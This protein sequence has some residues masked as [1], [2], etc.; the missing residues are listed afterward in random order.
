MMKH[1][2]ALHDVNW[3]RPC[4]GPWCSKIVLAP[5]PHQEHIESISDFIWRFCVNYRPLNAVTKPFE[6]PIPR[7]DA[8]LDNFGDSKGRLHFIS[9]DG[10]T[11]YHQIA[12]AENDQEKLAFMGPDLEKYCY[13]VMPFGPRNAPA[14]YTAMMRIMNTEVVT[15]FN[16]RYPGSINRVGTKNIIDD[17]LFWSTEPMTCLCYFRCVCEIFTKYRLS[18]NPKKCDFFRQRIEWLGHDLRPDGNSPAQSKFN[19]IADWVQPTTGSS[20]ASFIGLITFYNR[21][22]PQY[23]QK[24]GPLRTLAKQFHRRPIP[25]E[26]WTAPLPDLFRELKLAITSDPCLARFDESM[27]I[28]LKTDWSKTGMSYILMQPADD[29]A[30]RAALLLLSDGGTNTFD[31]LMSGARLRPIRFGSRRCTTRERHFHSFVGEAITGRWAIGQNRTYLWGAHFFWM[32]DCNS[33]KELL[34]YSGEIHQICR[35]SQELLGYHFTNLHRPARMMRDVDAL[36]RFYDDPLIREYDATTTALCSKDRQDRPAVYDPN[37]FPEQAFKCPNSLPKDEHLPSVS[38]SLITTTR[39]FSPRIT[40]PGF[41]ATFPIQLVSRSCSP[42]PA[43]SPNSSTAFASSTLSPGWISIGSSTGSIAYALSQLNPETA[44]TPV[45]IIAHDTLTAQL[46]YNL[47]TQALT[48]Q[49]SL[50]NFHA[51][52]HPPTGPHPPPNG[53]S[54]PA[55]NFI[56]R[57]GLRGLDIHSSAV[58]RPKQLA[59]LDTVTS[60]LSGLRASQ[61]TL[62]CFLLSSPILP[63]DHDESRYLSQHLITSPEISTNWNVRCGLTSSAFFGDAIAASRWIAIGVRRRANSVY[64][65]FPTPV[66]DHT[67]LH[68]CFEPHRNIPS[69]SICPFTAPVSNLEPTFLPPDITTPEFIPRTLPFTIA[70]SVDMPPLPVYDPDYPGPEPDCCVPS[71]QPHDEPKLSF[72]IPFSDRS[73]QC[74]ARYAHP[75]EIFRAYS[76]PVDTC[77]NIG[78]YLDKNPDAPSCLGTSIPFRTALAFTRCLFDCWSNPCT[79]L[80]SESVTHCLAY[81]PKPLPTQPDWTAAYLDDPD[82]H[83]ICSR[84]RDDPSCQWDKPTLN[85]VDAQYRASLRSTSIAFVNDRLVLYQRLETN[86]RQLML[87]IVPRALRRTIFS[88]YHASPTTGHMRKFKTLHRLRLRFFWPHMRANVESW[89]KECAHCIATSSHVRR[90]SELLFSWPVSVPFFILHVDLW[91]PGHT[92]EPMSGSTH[93]LAA[94][95]DLTGFVINESVA[96]ITASALA[97]NFMHHFLLKIGLCG[98]IVVDAG[99]TFL[100]VFEEMCNLLG[101][102]FHAASRGNHKAVSVERYFRYLNKAVTIAATDRATNHVFVETA[103]CAAYAWN[104]SCID[105]TE[106][107]R[108]VAA[109]GR[110]FKFPLDLSLHDPPS[111]VR[112]DVSAVHSF[113]RLAQSNST[114]AT[115]IL[116]IITEDRRTYH[117]ERVNDSRSQKLFAV[118]DIVM[119]RVQVQSKASTEKVA[120]LVYRLRGPYRIS[121]VLGHGAYSVQKFDQPT[122]PTLKYHAED[123]S[124]LPPAIRPVEPLDGPDLRYLNSNHAPIPH[125]LKA[126]FNIELYND[127]WFSEPLQTQPPQFSLSE[128]SYPCVEPP[129]AISEVNAENTAETDTDTTPTVPRVSHDRP[130][131]PLAL[132]ASALAVAIQASKDRLFFISYRPEGTLRSRWF[133]ISIDLEQTALEPTCVDFASSG[134]YY[135]HFYARHP[136]DAAEFTDDTARWWPEWHEYSLGSDDTIDYGARSLIYPSRTPDPAK[137]IAWATLL[138]LTDPSTC[139]LGPFNFQEPHLNPRNR[140]SSFRQ[141]VPTS[142]W[143]DLAELCCTH[144][145]TPPRLTIL[146]NPISRPKIS[147]KRT[148]A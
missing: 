33:L 76:F 96:N 6:Y 148:H 126:A 4:G 3:I 145:I 37:T 18:F 45:C 50:Q 136:S 113:L 133:L 94:M 63:S 121:T 112:G 56:S 29:E 69:A 100:G 68:S 42:L 107:I 25:L 24:A 103:Q 34:D 128:R 84:L 90:H 43:L 141:Y 14:V 8:A 28:F 88:A 109:V 26:A 75:L 20:L 116:R 139:L 81:S 85:S 27:P 60:I 115:S 106:I 135:A 124:L 47:C 102:R 137:Y 61:N 39:S 12:V 16:S 5:K 123:L 140:S 36:N 11:G 52:T 130:A 41:C 111:P 101:L 62:D 83:L 98:L 15:L 79:P 21:Y 127:M 30:S 64:P 78:P 54:I 132:S 31:S 32:C 59:W 73:G 80:S 87:I 99:S 23:E 67:S 35:I 114:F 10:K 58:T 17:S 2:S 9:V 48:S 146:G 117:R 7:C 105:G 110:E 104:S 13:T 1:I 131:F 108:S 40:E 138:S 122:G 66:S 53:N 65:S 71:P 143:A 93:V 147:R 129:S 95:C 22:I 118:D 70:P 74:F 46:T 91:S 119:V 44:A 144:G 92:T 77:P 86:E 142:L 19:L 89:C 97:T 57:Y 72:I 51:I 120:K 125:P 55:R 38:H 134:R 49:L 82:T